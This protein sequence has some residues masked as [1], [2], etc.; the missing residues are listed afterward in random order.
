MWRALPR[1]Q[2]VAVVV[3]FV[4]QGAIGFLPLFGG[5]GYEQS[6]ASGLVVPSAAAVA[7]ALEL[8][9]LS[10]SPL[11]CLVR[12]LGSGALL[13][14]VAFAT[15]L[16]H[17]LYAGICDFWGGTL[18]FA[19]TAGSGALMGG[20]WGAL[21]A[22][23]GRPCTRRRL[24]CVLLALSGPLGGIAIS[25]ARFYGSPMIF[26]FDPF[27]GFFSGTL[28]DTIVDARGRL[29]TYR[30]GSLST[31]VG[32]AL[33]AS[34]LTRRDDR[35]LALRPLSV[36]RPAAGRLMLGL[37]ALATSVLLAGS[38]PALAHWQTADSIARALM[39]HA[40]G[41]HCE[42][43]YPDSL[44]R[45]QADLLV[46]DCEEQLA[47]DEQT[48]GAR[49]DGRLTEYVFSDADEKRRLMGAAQTSIAKPWRREV[50]VQLSSYPHPILG[51]EIAHVLAGTFGRG[52]FRIAGSAGG[53]WP[54]PGLIEGVAVATSPDDDELTDAQWARAMLD[55]GTLP[56]LRQLFS[57][58][59]LGENAA[60]S[61]TIAGAFVAW[62]GSRWGKAAVRSWY[63]GESLEQLTGASWEA[64]DKQFRESLR[65]LAMPAEASTYAR[66]KF[67]RPSVW[68]RTCPHVVDALD[69]EGDQCREDHR[70]ERATSH[71]E[72]ALE[73]DPHDW[74][75]RLERARIAVG[76]GENESGR[77]ELK[78]ILG[79]EHA[80][81]T[82][83]DRAQEALADDDLAHGGVAT[84]AESYLALAAKSL[85]EDAARTL[86]VKAQGLQS[87]LARRA[88]NDLLVGEP[89]RPIDPWLGPLSLGTWAELTNRPVA[90][91]LIGKNLAQRGHYP[92]AAEWLDRSLGGGLPAASITRELL[93]QRAICAC[94]LD[95]HPA[96]ER[97][98]QLVEAHGSPFED[99]PGGG[100][101]QWLLRLLARCAMTPAL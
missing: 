67:E 39:G 2:L 40:A 85:D 44:Q 36:D 30:A 77:D 26:A 78:Q 79:D 56:P 54:N 95:D 13:A 33:V 86:E 92:R 24:A 80:P 35:R 10:L 60:K 93:R 46:R 21:F 51:H 81:R 37:L 53:L 23:F 82:W 94:A 100:R 99:A 83:R 84:A 66:A 38:G 64:L 43:L 17:A 90:A 28:Y 96:I 69:R 75:A 34:A 41:P 73:R 68:A 20:A 25:I 4:V 3:V 57:F 31:L 6:L 65:A 61:Y 76:Y 50:Y 98:K 27:F 7:T 88:I 19:L 15:A 71:Y 52:P 74:H 5:P 11:S 55:L 42:V 22:E 72:G 97:V 63:G 91:Y 9:T 59:F 1:Q 101:K 47:A 89:G 70:F 62:V 29:L 12:G 48:L 18:F 32:A 16:L 45:S 58:A 49:L 14:C 87:E 8:S